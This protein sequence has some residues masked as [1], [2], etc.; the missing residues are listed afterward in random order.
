MGPSVP[1]ATDIPMAP[2]DEAVPQDNR[3]N[4]L[5]VDDL[6]DKLLVYKTVLEELGQNLITAN[7]GEEALKV[8]LQNDFA[9][10]LLDVNMPGM[11][12]FETA[13][14]IRSRKKSA[15][16]PIIFLTAFS[17][18]IHAAQGYASGAVDFLLTPV[19]PEVLKAKVRVFIE[20]HQMRQQAERQAEDSARR[21]AAEESE[22]RKDAFLGMLAHELRNPLGPIRNS[23]HLLQ[24]IGGEKPQIGRLTD[25]IDRQVSHMTRLVDDL[26]DSTRL[27]S[28]KILLRR[29]PCDLK[30]ITRQTAEDYR[31]VIEGAGLNF[32]VEVPE[33]SFT[34][35]GDCTRLGQMIGNLL[36]NA[37]KF[38]PVGGSITVR[39][40]ADGEG[41]AAISVTDTGIGMESDVLPHVFEVFHQ[42]E[43]GLDRA[44]GGLGLGLAI[45]KGLASLHGGTVSAKSEGAGKGSTFTIHLPCEQ[46]ETGVAPACAPAGK[47]GKSKLRILIIE[48]SLD[49]AETT[50]MLLANDG[51]E[52]RTSSNGPAGITL[53]HDFMPQVILCDIGLPGIDGYQVV[54][55]LRADPKLANIYVIALTGYGREQDRK[56]AHDAGFDQHMTKP[57]DFR[58][59]RQTLANRKAN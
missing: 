52:V 16:T 13:T 5:L 23:V 3:V 18:D 49:A 58:L 43:Q 19:M 26:L 10:I 20:L 46:S 54:Q 37:Q 17:D 2:T 59:L 1:Q 53:A 42:A 6:P 38:T 51:H 31:S 55:R 27:A 9:V 21:R 24:Q 57:I 14:L 35:S 32:N 11:D 12:G 29:E 41:M 39:L 50:Q 28:G 44:R 36:H 22:R 30:D 4:I 48:D 40:A 47:A 45:V 33:H 7:S 25:V 56:H 34:M 8:V 15:R